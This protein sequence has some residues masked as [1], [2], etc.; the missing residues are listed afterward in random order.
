MKYPESLV[1]QLVDREIARV[2]SVRVGG[3]AVAS[4]LTLVSNSHWM[5]WL[6]AQTDEGRSC[7][8]SYLAYDTVLSEAQTA[9][10]KAVNLGASVGGGAEFKGHL[11]AADV[12]MRE[13]RHE[14]TAATI[15]RVARNVVAPLT[16]PVRGRLR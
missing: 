9:G 8:A 13:W 15:A 14:T 10:I 1:R 5:C 4:L 11:G 3:R 7:A 16:R 6:A 2:Y 12:W